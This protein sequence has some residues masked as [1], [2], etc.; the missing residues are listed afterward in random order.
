MKCKKCGREI[1]ESSIET[2]FDCRWQ[3]ERSYDVKLFDVELFNLFSFF[4]TKNTK[5]NS[6]NFSDFNF[7]PNFDYKYKYKYMPLPFDPKEFLSSMFL[8]IF[9][10][11]LCLIAY[12]MALSQK[13]SAPSYKKTLYV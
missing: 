11:S 6:I 2:C 5:Y 7:S 10:G 13:W 4:I 8:G 1:N 3:E 12:F 9:F